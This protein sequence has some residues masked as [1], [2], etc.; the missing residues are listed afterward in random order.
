MEVASSEEE[1]SQRQQVEPAVLP[2]SSASTA[3]EDTDTRITE[4]E[5]VG[6]MEALV[7]KYWSTL[8]CELCHRSNAVNK[9]HDAICCQ[10]MPSPF[11]QPSHVREK[12][13][14]KA[15]QLPWTRD[16]TKPAS[17][18]SAAADVEIQLLATKMRA[19]GTVNDSE[20]EDGSK[21]SKRAKTVDGT[22]RAG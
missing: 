21:E 13:E 10:R 5:H 14:D 18:S 4:G 19:V 8:G 12:N 22:V 2:Q 7:H 20:L 11:C 1:P 16:Q 3:D 6:S 17:S 9:I 15:R